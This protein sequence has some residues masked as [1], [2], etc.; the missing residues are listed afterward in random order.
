MNKR[1]L[2]LLAVTMLVV[3]ALFSAQVSA[4]NDEGRTVLK[5]DTMVGVSAPYTGAANPIRGINGG[6]IPWV[7]RSA[8]GE[9]RQSGKLKVEVQGLVLATTGANPV[10]TFKA[11]VSCLSIENGLPT[12]VNVSTDPVPATTGLASAGGGNA[13]IEAMLDLPHPCIAPIIFVANGGN[14]AWFSAT[15]F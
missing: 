13:E 9:L 1:M 7:L 4:K 5:F 3:A 15:G 14:G 6:G 12:T 11:T 8:E 2:G 10:A